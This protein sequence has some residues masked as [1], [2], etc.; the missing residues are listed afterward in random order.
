MIE[1]KVLINGYFE[2]ISET[3]CRAGS[4][5][6]LIKADN[7]KILVDTGNPQDQE[8]LIDVLKSEGLKP[9]DINIVINTHFHPD[10]SGCNYL[11]NKARF[12]VPGV[13]FW[14]DIFDRDQQNQE[15]PS[16]I[17]MMETPGHSED[18]CTI[19]VK[20]NDGIVAIAGD[21]F[22]RENDQDLKLLEKD[23]SNKNLFYQNRER[24]S[25]LADWIIP[26]H[27]EIFR[28]KK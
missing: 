24:I 11:F 3:R 17:T 20:T 23:C 19:L 18:S 27:G 15:L 2:E 9:E 12:I 28:T 22:W 26:G 21:L 7:K 16:G 4:S 1:V 5:I 14:E 6:V 8:K 10:H 13:S 25:K